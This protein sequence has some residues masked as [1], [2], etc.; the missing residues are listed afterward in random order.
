MGDTRRCRPRVVSLP[1]APQTRAGIPPRRARVLLGATQKVGKTTTLA[2]WAPATTLICDTQNGTLL[3]DGE[4]YVAHIT[5]WRSFERCVT[6]VCR[7]GHPFH[8]IGLDLVN[9]LWRFCDL[10][11]GKGDTPASAADD[12]GRSRSRATAAFTMVIGRLLA[13]PVGIWFLT[14]LREKTDKKGELAV[15][16]P[17]LDKQVYA[18]VAGAVD[19]LWLG[20]VTRSG[21]RVIHT[22][23]TP[24]F[25]AGSRIT[26]PSPLPMDAAAI[27]VAMDRGL[28]PHLYNE[29]GDRL[30]VDTDPG[31]VAASATPPAPVAAPERRDVDHTGTSDIA[32]PDLW[33]QGIARD[34]KAVAPSAIKAAIVAAGGTVPDRITSWAR[35]LGALNDAQRKHFGD[36]L[37]ALVAADLPIEPAAD[38]DVDADAALA[39][40]HAVDTD[41]AR[42]A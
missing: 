24:H 35:T 7:G 26:L 34:L 22:S 23:P 38:P 17:D 29:R 5:D 37:A 6:D 32:S 4:H 30:T 19:F 36:W 31:P 3:L 1:T 21:E 16:V 18:Y 41:D 27:A 28:N 42:A 40:A 9:D 15:Y 14:H 33:Y 13:A 8:T 12:Y 2:A 11:H 20:E 39:A 25:E 10:H